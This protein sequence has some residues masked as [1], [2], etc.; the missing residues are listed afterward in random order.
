MKSLLDSIE[1]QERVEQKR[2]R[3]QETSDERLKRVSQ[4][5]LEALLLKHK[6]NLK[7]DILKKRSLLEKEITNEIQA[8]I[9]AALAAQHNRNVVT[10]TTAAISSPARKRKSDVTI[11]VNE[12]PYQ[13]TP[14]KT[15][16]Y[17]TADV[18][19][20]AAQKPKRGRQK[21][22]VSAGSSGNSTAKASAAS[23]GGG[24]NVQLYCVCRTP[25]DESKFYIGCDRCEDWFHGS[26]VGITKSEADRMDSYVCPRCRENT[27]SSNE[28]VASAH[29]PLQD[30]HFAELRRLV[31]SL[32]AHKMSWPFL[33]PVS[34]SEVPDYYSVIKEPMDLQTI[35]S[36]IDYRQYSCTNDFVKDVTKMF[37]NC[38]YY[39]APNTP[40]YRCAEVLEIYF[41]E[42]LKSLKG[43][44]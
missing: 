3:K 18:S 43:K 34:A 22:A 44:L 17:A 42:R 5:R 6:E 12:T 29:T 39:N 11:A 7:R 36:K 27:A 28:S 21:K 19:S 1:R 32:R 37:D 8:D 23:S 35:Q 31:S 15:V 20:A 25:Y 26:C 24:G 9:N 4:Q 13:P 38:R 33:E 10:A 16:Q 2:Q 40:F 30:R 14:P 41:V